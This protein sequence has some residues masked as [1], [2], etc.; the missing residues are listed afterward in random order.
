MSKQK[1]LILSILELVNWWLTVV[2]KSDLSTYKS[3]LNG[4][5]P[6]QAV[7]IYV[8]LNTRMYDGSVGMTIVYL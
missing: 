7:L 3:V 5:K 8:L 6:Y 1:I 4:F 2:P